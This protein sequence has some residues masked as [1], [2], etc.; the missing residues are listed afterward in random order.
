MANV[1]ALTMA[2][3]QTAAAVRPQTVS[4]RADMADLYTRPITQPNSTTCAPA[5]SATAAGFKI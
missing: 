5:A 2:T 3:V 4:N 1:T